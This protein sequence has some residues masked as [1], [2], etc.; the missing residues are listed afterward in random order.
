MRIAFVVIKNLHRGGGI[1]RLTYEVGGRLA[2]RGHDVVVFSM[3]HYGEAVSI[4][5]MRVIEVPCLPGSASERLTASF[6]AIMKLLASKS[7]FDIVHMHTPMTGVFGLIT[8]LFRIPT[9]VQMHGV[10][11]QRSRWGNFAS[12]VIRLLER[13]VMRQMPFCTAV[14]QSV[15]DFYEKRYGRRLRYVPTG[16]SPVER[17]IA[18]DRIEEFGLVPGGYILFTARLVSEKGAQYLISAFRKMDTSMKL[19][20]AGGHLGSDPYSQQLAQLVGDDPRIVFPGFVEGELKRQLLSHAAVYVQPS[21]LEGLSIALLDAMSYELPCVVSDIP[22][23][24]EAIASAGVTFQ[25]GNSEDLR[26]K[27]QDLLAD[28]ARRAALGRAAIVRV[29]ETFS[30]DNVTDQLERLYEEAIQAIRGS[31][32]PAVPEFGK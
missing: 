9:V 2:R 26:E 24:L 19:V 18:T 1:E 8:K 22:E 5:G 14:S 6:T 32:S 7:E 27:L 20:I 17:S 10:D 31:Q 30:W 28:D 15:C 16:T 29:R 4:E 25:S 23:N 3:G 21:E 13:I 12:F 11:W